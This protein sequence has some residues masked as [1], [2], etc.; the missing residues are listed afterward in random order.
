MAPSISRKDLASSLNPT[1]ARPTNSRPG[2]RRIDFRAW[3]RCRAVQTMYLVE[4]AT[5]TVG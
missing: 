1:V 3:G 2:D 4:Q 5:K